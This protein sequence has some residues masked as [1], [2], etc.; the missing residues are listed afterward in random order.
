MFDES[1]RFVSCLIA[2]QLDGSQEIPRLRLFRGF[3]FLGIRLLQF[4]GGLEH[5]G[6]G[7]LVVSRLLLVEKHFTF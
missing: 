7:V 3:N 1:K 5:I 4:L 6:T 2:L